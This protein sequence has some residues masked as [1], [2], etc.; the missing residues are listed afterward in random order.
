MALVCL[1]LSPQIHDYV[2]NS[3]AHR[4]HQL[5]LAHSRRLKV[6]AAQRSSLQAKGDVALHGGGIEAVLFEFANAESAG[7]KAAVVGVRSMSIM[8]APLSGV[9][10]KI[11]FL[12]GGVFS[13]VR[14]HEQARNATQCIKDHGV[15]RLSKNR[16]DKSAGEKSASWWAH[17]GFSIRHNIGDIGVAR[18]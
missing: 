17:S 14:G 4:R 1:R 12:E 8:Y 16:S 5:R 15:E 2:V 10:M 11:M 18:R 9:S 6:H 13:Y 7:E 3:T